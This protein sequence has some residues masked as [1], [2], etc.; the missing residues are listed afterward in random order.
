VN[1]RAATEA[2]LP[3]LREL[4]TEFAA[5]CPPPAHHEFDVEQEIREVADILRGETAVIAENEG[6]A[7]GFVL[8]RRK[9]PRVGYVTDL[10][11]RPNSRRSGVAKALL[12]EVV[13][14]LRERGAEVI[15]LDVQA[16]NDIAW[17]VYERLGFRPE[18]LVLSVEAGA[19]ERRLA[20]TETAPS[21]GAV[22]IQT[23]EQGAVERAVG[24]FVPRL[25][26]SEG[27]R[28]S[29]PRRGWISVYDEL[30]DREPELLR[31]LAR[32]LSDR[33]G[34]VV[35]ALG[36]EKGRVVRYVLYEAGRVVDEY[37][38]VPEYYGPLPPGDVVGLGANS[39]VVARL[40]GA[41]PGRVRTIAKTASSP[42]DLPPPA[43]LA[44]AIAEL[45]GLGG[46]AL[47]YSSGEG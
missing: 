12:R 33:M 30:C 29:P 2:D 18:S 15:S 6:S 19:L 32:E 1:V 10:Y 11:V 5:E 8:A 37:L 22:H 35:V 20:T 38:S 45:M 3:T 34:A 25:G 14:R 13:A 24:Q 7:A 9:G 42:E 46:V 40:T 17:A 31:R 27:T 39:T 36:V 23:D 28:V 47:G 26:R 4:Y 16:A 44:G 21:F 41:D 43:E